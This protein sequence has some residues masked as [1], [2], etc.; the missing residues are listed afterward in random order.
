VGPGAAHGEVAPEP[1]TVA[2]A[3]P[4]TP[5]SRGLVLESGAQVVDDLERADVVHVT[6][7]EGEVLG[8]IEELVHTARALVLHAV[9]TRLEPVATGELATAAAEAGVVVAVPYVRR[10]FP[11]VRLAR[12]R[13][14][15]G[16]PGPIQ[17]I[18]GWSQS[19]SLT[20]WCDLVE[21]T[22]RHRI[23]RLTATSLAPAGV[24][25]PAGGSG[26]TAPAA[27]LVETDR[28]AVGSVAVSDTHPVEGGALLVV[29]DGSEESLV[30]H[31]GR[32]EVLDPVGPRS[33]QRFQRGVGADVSRY[34]TEPAG[35]PQGHHDCWL[36][37]LGDAHSAVRGAS[38]D[39]LPTLVDLARSATIAASLR[40]SLSSSSWERVGV[41]VDLE[42]LNT[43]EGRTA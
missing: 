13:V 43:T 24:D 11:M 29:L 32:P 4:M 10:Y 6:V 23:T 22:T 9:P 34:S 31:E 30:F 42:L 16:S 20:A 40:A 19:D 1:L 14:R 35:R 26:W 12:R 37:F 2:F 39:G 33:T 36:A 17:L 8:T 5:R 41:D 38:P 25:S 7:P 15:S 3:G 27:L 28:G 21:F 18:H